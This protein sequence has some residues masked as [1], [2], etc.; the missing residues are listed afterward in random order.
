MLFVQYAA[1]FYL[2]AIVPIDNITKA[3]IVK[4]YISPFCSSLLDPPSSRG[5]FDPRSRGFV[6][7]FI[8]YILLSCTS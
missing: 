6:F 3:I 1:F 2:D 5:V 4:T 8:L 7:D